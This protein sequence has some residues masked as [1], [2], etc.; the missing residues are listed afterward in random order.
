MKKFQTIHLHIAKPSKFNQLVLFEI[1]FIKFIFF[2]KNQLVFFQ[3][4]LNLLSKY[5]SY[6]F[7]FFKMM[8][9]IG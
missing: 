6:V 5:F 7:Q 1:C 9:I 3:L 2:T 8:K 4:I